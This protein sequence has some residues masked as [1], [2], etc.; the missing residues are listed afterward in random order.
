MISRQLLVQIDAKLKALTGNSTAFGGVMLVLTGDFFQLPPVVG[1]PLY[2]PVFHGRMDAGQEL[3]DQFHTVI[4]LRQN[5]RQLSD[6]A[7]SRLLDDFRTAQGLSP[8][9]ME[10]LLSRV[11][12]DRPAPAAAKQALECMLQGRHV[13][14]MTLGNKQRLAIDRCFYRAAVAAG[15]IPVLL[16]MEFTVG[17]RS[18]KLTDDDLAFMRRGSKAADLHQHV[19]ELLLFVGM[20]V[21]CCANV[22]TAH[23]IAN[24]TLATVHSIQWQLRTTFELRCKNGQHFYRPSKQPDVVWILIS[25]P[26]HARLP[27]LPPDLPDNAWPMLRWSPPFKSQ[28]RLHGR[29]TKKSITLTGFSLGPAM[30]LTSYKVQG[31]TLAAAVVAPSPS[32]R[33]LHICM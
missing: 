18:A 29:K 32:T 21:M 2:G 27:N 31:L 11:V 28:A 1:T 19:P 10:L 6:A 17:L 12:D 23:G 26:K 15:N 9:S 24:G 22:S 7:L 4:F 20:P 25:Q 8:A 30:A 5:M 14:W 13:P 3:W 16:S 33:T